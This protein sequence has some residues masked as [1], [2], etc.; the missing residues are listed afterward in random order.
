MVSLD[1]LE[2]EGHDV[3]NETV[4]PLALTYLEYYYASEVTKID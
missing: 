1:D 4:I 2:Y 3:T